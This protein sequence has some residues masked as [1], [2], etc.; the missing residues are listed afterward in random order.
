MV[1]GILLG[2]C[3]KEGNRFFVNEHLVAPTNSLYRF[4]SF[5]QSCSFL[6]VPLDLIFIK[7]LYVD[8]KYI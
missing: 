3:K 6:C 7:L 4:I 8:Y 5:S 2:I 1:F